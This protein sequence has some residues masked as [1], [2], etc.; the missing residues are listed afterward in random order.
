MRVLFFVTVDWAFL[1]FRTSLV[2]HLVAQGIEVHVGTSAGTRIPD[3]T[4]LGCIHHVIDFERR[5]INPLHELK[6]LK[7]MRSL[8][9]QIRPDVVH[10]FA[11][12]PALY[13]GLISNSLRH[14]P[15]MSTITGLGYA[16]IN[17]SLPALIIRLVIKIGFRFASKHRNTFLI[18]Q[19]P[20]DCQVF[21]QAKMVRK[22]RAK[23]IPGSGVDI[24]KF[25]VQPSPPASPVIALFPAR[26]LYDKGIREIVEAMRILKRDGVHVILRLAG[27]IDGDNPRTATAADVAE[28]S[29]E[30]LV[31]FLGH[32]ADMVP[33]YRDCHFVVL[34]SYREGVPMALLEAAACGRAIVTTDVPGCREVVVDGINGILVKVR[35]AVSLAEGI[36]SLTE[37]CGLRDHFARAGRQRVE[38][39]F[40]SDVVNRQV[41]DYYTLCRRQV[42]S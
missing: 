16:F 18:F 31:E 37:N 25:S 14:I 35:D 38:S 6:T 27:D 40:S 20:D 1:N 17:R 10:S 11:I 42:T 24:K 23:T 9:Q 7:Q 19:N 26:L 21:T 34:P 12:K 2:K 3:I 15:F 29:R 32:Q 22:D 5:G 30:G 13:V 8:C 41:L 36:R 28:W 4:A 39:I 33:A